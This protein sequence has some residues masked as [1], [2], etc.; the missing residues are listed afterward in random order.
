VA[1]EFSPLLNLAASL[2]FLLVL[3]WMISRALRFRAHNTSWRGLRF[4]FDGT[5]GEAAKAWIL[6]PILGALSL[7]LLIPFAVTKQKR[8]LINHLHF[9]TARFAVDLPGKAVYGVFAWAAA[10]LLSVVIV[11]GLVVWTVVLPMA[12]TLAQHSANGPQALAGMLGIGMFLVLG[13][14]M[15]LAA[16]YVR[17]RMANLVWNRST[18]AAGDGAAHGFLSDQRVRAYYLIVLANWLLTLLTLGLYRPF[19]AVRVWRYRAEHFALLPAGDLDA[20]VGMQEDDV[21]VTG[22]E[23]TDVLDVDLGW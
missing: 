10:V 18:L 8:Y 20:F 21:R 3:P 11:G 19:A 23:A 2:L 4:G 1:A 14:A 6:W 13:L 15:T 17:V 7:G 5:V 16:P 22:E 12:G 9:A